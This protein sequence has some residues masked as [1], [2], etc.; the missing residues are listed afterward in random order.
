MNYASVKKNDIANGTGVRVCLF[1]SGCKNHCKGCFQP[2]TWDFEYGEKYTSEVEEGILKEL[3]GKR[4]EGLSIL[5]GDPMEERNQKDVAGLLK[6]EKELH[7]KHT[8]WA[9]TGYLF[10][11]LLP[12]GK[13]NTEY[14]L[15]ILNNLDV[16]VDGRFVEEKKN[17]S[18]AFRGSENQRIID[19]Q[20]SL[21]EGTVVEIDF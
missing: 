7:P 4:Y 9:Y 10:E 15:D 18:L 19:V 6:K 17:I 13:K 20:K 14:S 5:G 11:D 8:S 2:E 21:R 12:G 1:V 16:L 3:D